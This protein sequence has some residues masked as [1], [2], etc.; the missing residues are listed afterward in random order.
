MFR[1]SGTS[2]GGRNGSR[3]N[4]YYRD[5]SMGRTNVFV[6]EEKFA[7]IFSKAYFGIDA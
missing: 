7:E 1:T 6:D 4:R 3:I 2:E 5:Y